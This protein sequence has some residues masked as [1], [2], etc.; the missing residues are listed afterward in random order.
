[1]PLDDLIAFLLQALRPQEKV[2]GLG[3]T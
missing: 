2:I 1:M 3:S